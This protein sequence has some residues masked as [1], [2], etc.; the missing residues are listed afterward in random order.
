MEFTVSVVLFLAGLLLVFVSV[1][2][3]WFAMGWIYLCGALVGGGFFIHRSL[4]LVGNPSRQN[5]IRCFLASLVQLAL[6][7]GTAIIDTQV[8]WSGG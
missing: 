4:R 7:M 5:A 2:P 3:V 8:G 6:L 1:L